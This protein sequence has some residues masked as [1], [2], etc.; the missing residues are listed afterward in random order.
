MQGTAFPWMAYSAHAHGKASSAGGRRPWLAAADQTCDCEPRALQRGASNLYFPVLESALSIPP[1][2]D[3]LQ[4]AL[5][6]YWN[7]ILNTQ[8]AD[9]ATFIRI[10]AQGE[11]APVVNELGLG[12]G[13]AGAADRRPARQVQ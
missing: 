7:P 12:P 1:W 2:S 13:G 5:G 9:R 3:A 8:P 11:L 4:E 10:L 6:V